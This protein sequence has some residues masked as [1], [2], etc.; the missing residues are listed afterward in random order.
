MNLLSTAFERGTANRFLVQ[1]KNGCGCTGRLRVQVWI[2]D[3]A[4]A[5]IIVVIVFLW[6]LGMLLLVEG[7]S[8]LDIMGGPISASAMGGICG[9]GHHPGIHVVN[10]L[11]VFEFGSNALIVHRVPKRLMLHSV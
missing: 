10:C 1:R 5:T 3:R 9:T 6:R 4:D 11:G 7:G 8:C 2:V